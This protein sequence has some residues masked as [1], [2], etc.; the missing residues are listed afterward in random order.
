VI[1]VG[2]TVTLT[3]APRDGSGNPQTVAALALSVT[4]PDGTSVGP[5]T[6]TGSVGSYSYAY[7]TTQA[8]RHVARW[9]GTGFAYAEPFNVWPADPGALF[10]VAEAKAA[11]RFASL[12]PGDDDER[13]RLYIAA[14]TPVIEDIVGTVVQRTFVETVSGRADT[15]GRSMLFLSRTPVVS[16]QSIVGQRAGTFEPDLSSLVIDSATGGLLL[17]NWYEWYGPVTVSYTAGMTSVPANIL[18]AAQEEFRYLWQVGQQGNRPSF[19]EG[20]EPTMMTPS[21]FAVRPR[22]LEL[23]AASRRV[24]GIA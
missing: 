12:T 10:S 20:G 22:V 3:S 9:T 13:L 21:G 1:D 16:V 24:A 2:D 8:G 17:G 18:L 15:S 19:G 23:C 4:L 14:V 7:T 5:F 11:L 6:P